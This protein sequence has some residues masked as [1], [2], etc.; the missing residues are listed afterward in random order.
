MRGFVELNPNELAMPVAGVCKELVLIHGI[1]CPSWF[2]GFGYAV[3]CVD[4][5]NGMGS[6][7]DSTWSVHRSY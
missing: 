7:Q 3:S 5:E 1:P 2:R 4:D 6:W